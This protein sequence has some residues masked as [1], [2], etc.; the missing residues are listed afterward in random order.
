MK[1]DKLVSGKELISVKKRRSQI[2]FFDKFEPELQEKRISEGWLL[3]KE[4]KS[5]VRMKKEKPIDEQ[6]EDEVWCLFATL[7]FKQMNRDRHLEI[8]YGSTEGASKQIDV[9][10]VDEETVLFIECK[11]AITGKKGDFKTELEAIKGIKEG[12]YNTVRS[13]K[14]YRGKKFKYIF[15]T[16]NYEIIEADKNRMKDLGIHHFDEYGIKYF[17][18]LAKHLGDS[19]RYQLLGAL[20]AGQK[21]NSM[22]NRIPAIEGRMGGNTYY[23]FSIEPEKLLKIAYVL[24]R[25]EANHDMMPTYQRIIKKSRLKEIQKF[26]DQGG[27]FPN[28][29]IISIDTCGKK[30]KFDQ[31]TPQV[32][33]S[34]SR[35]GILYLPQ[36][37]RSAYIIDGQHRLY[38][39]A[40]SKYVAKD[41]IPV[42][43]FVN[44]DKDKQVELFMEINENQKTVSKN[45][46]NTLNADLLWTSEDKNKQRKALRLNI[47][48]R[49][50]ELQSSPFFGRIVIGE[51]EANSY[52]CLTI[53]TI[54]N[55]LKSTNFF[56]RYG[57]ENIVIEDGS[58]DRGTNEST[59]EILLPFLIDCFQY[60][61]DELPEEWHLS[62]PNLGILTI[63]NTIHAL[64]RVINDIVNYL[65]SSK[66]INPKV[67]DIKNL[68]EQVKEY[69]APLITYFGNISEEQRKEIKTNYGSGGKTRV[70]RTFELIIN[71]DKPDFNPEGLTEWIRDNTKQFNTESF[72]II[73]DLEYIIKK[74][75]K[76]RLQKKYAEKWLVSGLPPKVY[77]QA[78]NLMGKQNYEN[79]V[80]GISKNVTIW[81][82]VSIAN[83]RDIATFNSNWSELFEENYTRP[84]ELRMVG[85]KLAKTAWITKL[86]AIAGNNSSNY[87]FS[88][89]EYLFLKSLHNWLVL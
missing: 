32:E 42:V 72:S 57:K 20:F 51:N 3:D 65:I 45:L 50:G 28:S 30:L 17:A 47:S 1:T 49:L 37:Y 40:E 39:Y 12:L 14:E 62:D 22:D 11:C 59:R 86:A 89:E 35:I 2:Y 71:Q 8:N 56:T 19:A 58:F 83:C 67:Y 44:L 27:F 52:C 87:S 7:G 36:F 29:L 46:Q 41:S 38:G 69:L 61:K 76:E 77:K 5:L 81:D 34:N 9:F 18:E 60:F 88:E 80:N 23:S 26:V 78:N 43:A 68:A 55:A 13:N 70:W 31:A 4:L 10:A 25:N 63:N 24:H 66:K 74:D 64:I 6:F 73:H 33:S 79:S 85:G 16:K 82:C 84:E 53:D 75:F 54:E 15:A 21:I 48:Q